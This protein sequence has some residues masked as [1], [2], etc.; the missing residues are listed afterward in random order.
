MSKILLTGGSGK[1]GTEIQKHI[2]VLAPSRKELDILVKENIYE[3]CLRHSPSLI[4]HAAA[5]SIPENIYLPIKSVPKIGT[6]S[7][8]FKQLWEEQSRNN[9]P[10]KLLNKEIIELRGKQT[11]VLSFYNGGQWMPIKK[12]IRHWYDGEII[13]LNQKVELTMFLEMMD[14]QVEILEKEFKNKF[15]NSI[16]CL[17]CYDIACILHL[18]ISRADECVL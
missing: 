14:W 13:K 9:K 10:K 6:K 12:I 1:L 11:K 5:Y 7:V 3:Y 16:Y 15:L 18:L 4:V 2:E 17:S 8:T